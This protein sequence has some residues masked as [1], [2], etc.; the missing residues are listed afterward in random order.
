MIL[1]VSAVKILP[2][3]R[4]KRHDRCRTSHDCWACCPCFRGYCVPSDAPINDWQAVEGFDQG[5]RH[6][7][8][9][10]TTFQLK[11]LQKLLDPQ[12]ERE[13][14]KNVN[15]IKKGF[16]S[17]VKLIFLFIFGFHFWYKWKIKSWAMNKM[18]TPKCGNLFAIPNNFGDQR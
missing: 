5:G 18:W 11:A 6:L 14:C 17:I 4:A 12:N 13:F 16:T 9:W 2:V 1:V 7:W 3:I 15:K 8:I 10:R